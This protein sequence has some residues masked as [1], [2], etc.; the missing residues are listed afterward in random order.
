MPGLAYQLGILLASP[1][2]T[3]QYALRDH[4]GYQW[5]I[6]SFEIV[7]ILALA[8]LA[9]GCAGSGNWTRPDTSK[10]A[11]A[12]DY[13]ACQSLARE[14]TQRDDAITIAISKTGDRVLKIGDQ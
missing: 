11:A 12:A 3:I 7:S 10:E 5:A 2:N 8:L 6:A 14:A 9:T 1:T 13:S 4:V